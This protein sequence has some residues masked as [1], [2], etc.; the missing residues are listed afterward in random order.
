MAT[1]STTFAALLPLRGA[2]T[3][4]IA[5]V[6]A[7]VKK[8]WRPHP[9]VPIGYINGDKTKPVMINDDWW[10]HIKDLGARKLGGAAFPS[11]PE[12]VTQSQLTSQISSVQAQVTAT[13]DQQ[14]AANAQSLEALRQVVQ[15]LTS[16]AAVPPV[17]LVR[18]EVTPPPPV[19]SPGG[20]AGGE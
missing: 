7:P 3:A 12:V 20:G 5:L 11:L 16:V 19:E 4:T 6:T 13:Q 1:T 8:K 18:Q 14:N 2:S 10:G 9:G 15:G 17:V